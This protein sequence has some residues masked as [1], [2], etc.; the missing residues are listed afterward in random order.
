MPYMKCDTCGGEAFS[1]EM[2]PGVMECFMSQHGARCRGR[3]TEQAAAFVADLRNDLTGERCIAAFEPR[4]AAPLPSGGGVTKLGETPLVLR[5]HRHRRAA[6]GG[7]DA[8][9]YELALGPDAVRALHLLTT[10][11][12]DRETEAEL[13]REIDAERRKARASRLALRAMRPDE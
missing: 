9:G 7:S 13:E 2:L 10:A 8:L 1:P 5:W 11:W 3:L 6:G 12:L 4:P